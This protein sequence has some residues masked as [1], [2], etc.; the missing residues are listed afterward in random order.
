MINKDSQRLKRVIEL[1]MESSSR[2]NEAKP[3]RY[4]YPLAMANYGM[5]EVIEAIDSLC[6]F[7]TTMWEKTNKFE[8][9]FSSYQGCAKAVMVNSGSSA[10]LLLSFLLTNPRNSILKK[11]DYVL[12]PVVTWP[13]HIWSPMMA[14]LNV[15]L[16]DVDPATL[17]INIEDLERKISSKTKAIFLVHLLGNPC[18][19]DQIL[20]IAESHQLLIIEDCCEALGSEWDGTKVGNFGWGGTFSFFFSHHIVTMEGGM[21]ACKDIGIADDLKILRA[22]GWLRNVDPE[23]CDLE[24][25]DL[26]PRYAFVNWGFNVRPTELQAGFGLQQ[27][28]KLPFLNKRRSILAEKFFAFIDETIFLTRPKVHQKAK[29]NWFAVP[30][31]VMKD[32]PF[33]RNE[34]TNYLEDCGIETRPIVAGNIARHPV[35][36]LFK[37]SFTESY[38]GADIV[39]AS[40]FYIGLLPLQPDDNMERL[41]D[42]LHK[43][44]NRY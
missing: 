12:V 30:V 25:Y 5:E 22:H 10:N 21:I 38:P 8:N 13:T 40:G 18:D 24:G 34:I 29:P 36:R 23:Y 16:V 37:G 44:L 27:L 3:Q 6:S 26:D 1:L 28:E 9:R 17:N 19:M 7:R 33:T 4:W 15:R 42:C 11:G 39:H 35:A 41:L 31:L 14:G 32:A 20:E 2:I 43:F